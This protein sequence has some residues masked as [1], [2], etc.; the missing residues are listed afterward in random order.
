[1]EGFVKKVFMNEEIKEK[2]KDIDS[3]LIHMWRYL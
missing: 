2:L 1:M 3:R